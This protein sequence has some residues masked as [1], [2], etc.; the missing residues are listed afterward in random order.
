MKLFRI[1]RVIPTS[2]FS[3]LL[4]GFAIFSLSLGVAARAQSLAVNPTGVSGSV[5]AG[6]VLFDILSPSSDFRVDQGIFAAANVEKGFGAHFYLTLTLAYLRT[7]GQTNYDYTTLSGD[8]YTGSDVPFTT[9]LFQGGLGLRFKLID[10]SW[11]RPYVE[12]GGLAG[13]YQLKYSNTDALISGPSNREK[14]TDALLDFG[15]YAE[16]GLELSLS[17]SF[18]MRL[19]ARWFQSQTKPFETLGDRVVKYRGEVYYLSV[20]KQF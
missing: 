17:G 1:L 4:Q 19:A 15:Y 14:T 20:L 2:F 13:Y 3:S 7:E 16:G 18:G 5:G 8:N 12:G 10:R 6:I 9:N 11:F